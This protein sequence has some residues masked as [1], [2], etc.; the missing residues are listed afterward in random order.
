MIANPAVADPPGE[1]IY[2]EGIEVYGQE[3]LLP[4]I[5]FEPTTVTRPGFRLPY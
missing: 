3:T 2:I 1:L 4:A 5:R